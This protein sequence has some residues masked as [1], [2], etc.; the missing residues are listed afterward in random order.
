MTAATQSRTR[1]S[2]Y[3]LLVAGLVT[4]LLVAFAVV[5]ALEVPLLT[6]P[7]P[8]LR[9]AGALAGALGVGLLLVD[10]AIPVPSSIVMTVHGALFGAVGGAALSLLGGTGATLVAVALGR[11]GRGPLQ[12]LTLPEHGRRAERLFARYGTA[13]IIATRPVPVLAETVAV[14]AGT[15]GM[16]LRRAAWAGALGNT[17]PAV[18][19]AVA[20]AAVADVGGTALVFGAVIALSAVVLLGSLAVARA[21]RTTT[22][23]AA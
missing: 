2:A 11:R 14:V 16:P 3:P 9:G 4:A 7:V 23:D 20:G 21:R 5:E 18:V 12:R 13:A 15:A 19:Y 10:V 22:A 8:A 17:V 6:D 1:R